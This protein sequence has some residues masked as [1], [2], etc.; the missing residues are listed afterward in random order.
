M[1]I[2]KFSVLCI[3]TAALFF[4]MRAWYYDGYKQGLKDAKRIIFEELRK[5]K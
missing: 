3:I 5:R 1:D 4:C 2:E